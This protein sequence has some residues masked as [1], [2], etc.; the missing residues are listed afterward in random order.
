MRVNSIAPERHAVTAPIVVPVNL[1]LC[2]I[3]WHISLWIL[4]NKQSNQIYL[5]TRIAYPSVPL[6]LWLIFIRGI[7]G[8]TSVKISRYLLTLNI[9]NCSMTNGSSLGIYI[10]I[11]QG[12]NGCD[13]MVDRFPTTYVISAYCHE[14]FDFEFHSWRGVLDTT[15]CDKVYQWLAADQWFSPGTLGFLHK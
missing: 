5:F 6:A 14:S 1:F 9:F 12:R 7:W 11:R 13:S 3:A 15:I 8:N 2:W 10:N 4:S